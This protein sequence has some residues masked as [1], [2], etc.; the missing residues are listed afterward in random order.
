MADQI[1]CVTEQSGALAA[2]N[3]R[4]KLQEE[5]SNAGINYKYLTKKLVEELESHE[6]KVFS[7]EHGIKYSKKLIAWKI[8]QEA[9]KDAHKLLDH[10][11]ADRQEIDF[12][13]SLMAAVATYLSAQKNLSTTKKG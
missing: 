12:S 6:I 11:P 13:G 5:F 1:P 3:V 9:R 2:E 7:S 8:R 4:K 10:Y